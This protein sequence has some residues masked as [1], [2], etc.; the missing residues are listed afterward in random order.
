MP[1]PTPHFSILIPLVSSVDKELILEVL[2]ALRNQAG[3]TWRYEVVLP[4]RRDDEVSA[5]IRRDYTEAKLIHVPLGTSIPAM[6]AQALGAAR[7]DWVA[8]T[9][10][11]CIPSTSWLDT[12][13]SALRDP[14]VAAIGGPIHNAAQATLLDRA[15]FFCEYLA[16]HGR[17]AGQDGVV[18]A[19]G[20]AGMNFCCRRSDLSKADPGQLAS[21]F[22]ER[23]A[24]PALSADGRSLRMD[25]GAMVG[26]AK[27]FPLSMFLHQRYLYSRAYAGSQLTTVRRIVHPILAPLLVPLLIVRHG[28]AA[29]ASRRVLG[30]WLATLPLQVLFFTAWAW[31]EAVGAA[32]GP[33]DALGRIE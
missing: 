8:V 33:G 4:D 7:G 15:T 31:G 14:N 32:L 11:H 26:H 30:Q 20:L 6:L 22:W 9:E 16:F 19:G 25:K 23:S 1:D 27:T 13:A 3:E 24:L 2:D 28:R 21:E 18:Q 17:G 10:D 5:K 29:L 12:F